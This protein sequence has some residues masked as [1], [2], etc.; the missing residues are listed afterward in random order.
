MENK[1]RMKLPKLTLDDLLST[2]EERDNKKLEKVQIIPISEITPFPNHPYKVNEDDEM[3]DMA[4]S[5]AERGVLHPIIVR[6]KQNGGYEMISGHRRKRASEIAG[7]TTIKAIVREMTDEEAT[8]IMVDSNKQR[9]KVLPSEK[10]FAYKMKLEAMKKQGKRNDLT[11][12]PLG[13]KLE[14]KS[15]AE[16][17]GEE[18]DDSRN[19]VYRY[20]RLTELIPE[21]LEMVDREKDAM[22]L[23]PA[24]EISYLTKEEQTD[25]LDAMKSEDAMPTHAQAIRLRRMSEKG[26]LTVDDIYDIMEEQKP[27]QQEKVNFGYNKIKE[28]FPE[29][30]TVEQMI[31]VMEDLLKNYKAQWQKL[32]K[33]KQYA[34]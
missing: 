33:Q 23:R 20:I 31:N 8:I 4:N 7:M 22:A 32:E 16:K 30:Y 14:T 5:I 2:Q 17:I 21:F 11:S 19:N 28:Y 1:E 26:E 15:T 27:N 3:L 18:F 6:P 9:E 25:L 13:T 10:A 34:R 24:V 12:S 29:N